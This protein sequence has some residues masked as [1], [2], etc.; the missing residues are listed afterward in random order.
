MLVKW[1]K[2]RVARTFYARCGMVRVDSATRA[3]SA[4]SAAAAAAQ[5]LKQGLSSLSYPLVV[6]DLAGLG[7]S[8]F[9]QLCKVKP[10]LLNCN[11]LVRIQTLS[12]QSGFWPTL[13]LTGVTFSY[14]S[15]CC[16]AIPFIPNTVCSATA[17]AV[18]VVAV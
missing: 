6:L 16:I 13:Y 1:P 10:E 11:L 8:V 14:E 3:I 12:K 7:L 5:M 17:S 9:A 18:N 15:S 4:T 2:C